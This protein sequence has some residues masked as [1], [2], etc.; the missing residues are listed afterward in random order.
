MTL[1]PDSA[2]FLPALRPKAVFFRRNSDF[3]NLSVYGSSPGS[4]I[5]SRYAFRLLRL[6][7]RGDRAFVKIRGDTRLTHA[8]SHA[9]RS[10]DPQ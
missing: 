7:Q 8:L 9:P 5:S 3:A 1:Q 6:A 2:F 10:R 4:H